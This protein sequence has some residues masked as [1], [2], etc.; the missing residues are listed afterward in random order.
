MSFPISHSKT[1]TYE[2]LH[3]IFITQN[4]FQK[5]HISIKLVNTLFKKA[6][7]NTP[8]TFNMPEEII[9][10]NL[11]GSIL[12]PQLF[13]KYFK[14]KEKQELIKSYFPENLSSLVV[15]VK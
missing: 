9:N 6:N 15:S 12:L 13:H 8:H 5:F 4:S 14:I 11:K 2:L 7:K 10:S 3:R 1:F